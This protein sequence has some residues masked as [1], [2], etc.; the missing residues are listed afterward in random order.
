MLLNCVIIDNED[1]I[2]NTIEKHIIHIPFLYLM[3]KFN[4]LHDALAYLS[5]N[6]IDLIFV[7]NKIDDLQEGDFI[8]ELG[9]DPMV[10]FLTTE[11]NQI[12]KSNRLNVIDYLTKPIRFTE[13]IR[14][15]VKAIKWSYHNNEVLPN[16]T[17]EKFLFI[18]SEYKIIRIELN[19]IKYIEGMNEYIR[20]HREDGK[21]IMTLLSLKSIEKQ[22]PTTNFMRVHKSYIINLEK[23]QEVEANIIVCDG[24]KLIPVSRMYKDKFQEY[25]SCNVIA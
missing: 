3:Q 13:L 11:E 12:R 17:Q 14:S 18:K 21:P 23:I 24:G 1:S 16:N 20:I 9:Y 19:S 6:E 25:L 10:V 5:S 8:H 4:C 22:L 2:I 15:A 7:D